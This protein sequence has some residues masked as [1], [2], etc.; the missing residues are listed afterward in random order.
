ML[1]RIE[2]VLSEAFISLRRNLLM[3]IAAVS[4]MAMALFLLGGM[5]HAY[6][7]ISHQ[8]SKQ[9]ENFEL[10]VFLMNGITE[11]QLTEVAAKIDAIDGVKAKE[12]ITPEE[13]MKEFQELNPDIPVIGLPEDTFPGAF[14][15]TPADIGQS[16]RIQRELER[17]PYLDTPNAV[18]NA[19]EMRNILEGLRTGLR[20]LGLSMGGL[21][22]LTG[23]III[24]NAIRLTILARRREM[25]IMQL[26]GATRTTV[27]SPLLMEG[28]IQGAAGGLISAGLLWVTIEM[29]KGVILRFDSQAHLEG[30]PFVAACLWQMLAG[31]VFGFICSTI[32]VREPR[33]E[34]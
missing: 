25:R 7:T 21:M 27:W 28:V 15:V 16:K 13:G 31:A 9:T 33:K 29:V 5:K 11:E 32:A 18:Q 10:R 34:S 17:L 3:T 8:L 24:Y 30:L 22:L 2:F 1:D 26:V 20:N 4:T 6:S 23:G 14:D 12:Y 19:D